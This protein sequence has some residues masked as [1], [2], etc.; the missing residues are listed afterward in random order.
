MRAVHRSRKC[1]WFSYTPT[2]PNPMIIQA[3]FSD[4]SLICFSPKPS[5][6]R[7]T[8]LHA[9]HQPVVRHETNRTFFFLENKKTRELFGIV[10]NKRIKESVLFISIIQK[11]KCTIENSCKIRLETFDVSQVKGNFRMFLVNTSQCFQR[12]Y[13]LGPFQETRP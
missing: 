6:N 13:Q 12:K 2:F 3:P 8:F 5:Q 11:V 9:V 1:L 4:P 7:P 10:E